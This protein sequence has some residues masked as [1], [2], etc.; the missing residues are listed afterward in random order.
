MT[1]EKIEKYLE[2]KLARTKTSNEPEDS[3]TGAADFYYYRVAGWGASDA[4]EF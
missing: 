3:W 2:L 1:H 4:A